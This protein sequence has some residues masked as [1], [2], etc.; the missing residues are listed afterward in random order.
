MLPNRRPFHISDTTLNMI[1]KLPSWMKMSNPESVGARFLESIFGAELN[2]LSRTSDD[3]GRY[4]SFVQAPV[5]EPT[6]M[7]DVELEEV[8][9]PTGMIY[10][11]DTRAIP[12]SLVYDRTNFLGNPPT[13]I[14][15][16]DSVFPSGI[17]SGA[18]SMEWLSADPTGYVVLQQN[19]SILDPSST[20]YY[21]IRNTGNVINPVPISGNS[22]G[23]GYVGLG[24]N[25]SYDI[26]Q[27]ELR[28]SLEK[29][30]PCGIWITSSGTV[31]A[32]QPSGVLNIYDYYY[33]SDGKKTYFYKGFNNPYGSGRYDIADVETTVSP[34]QGTVKVYDILNLT[35][36]GTPTEVPSSGLAVYHLLSGLVDGDNFSTWEYIG[37]SETVPESIAP[38]ALKK[39]HLDAS[40]FYIPVSATKLYDVS[41]ELLPSSGYLDTEVPPNSGTFVWISGGGP[42]TNIIRFTNPM[43]TYQVEYSYV[44]YSSVR[45]ISAEPRESQG[46]AQNKNNTIYFIDGTGTYKQVPTEASLSNQYAVR[47]NPYTI[48]PGNTVKVD[49][50]FYGNRSEIWEDAK[51]TNKTVQLVRHNIGYSDEFGGL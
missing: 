24:K 6:V 27:P 29:K 10:S 30:Y 9:S 21:Q 49:V 35:S 50:R 23:V 8:L 48:R 16:Q 15:Y 39:E 20:L 3:Y 17:P 40:G 31:Q 42:T 7:Y 1:Q 37:F 5:D 46:V 51:N 28:L 47:I 19:V 34:T 13:R 14:E 33:D 11:S 36:S 4:S 22:F 38:E 25:G 18:I 2:L 26:V 45:S 44:K 12:I 43:S 32:T 41:W